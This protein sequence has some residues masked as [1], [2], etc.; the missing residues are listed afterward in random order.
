[1]M[2]VTY[3]DQEIES[4]VRERKLLPVNWTRRARLMPKRGHQERHLDI[5]GDLG[6]QFR[7]ILRQ[8]T[9]NVLDFSAILAVRVPQSNQV[10]RLRR[11]NG[12]SHE[13]TNHIEGGTFYDFHIHHATERYQ[14]RSAREDAYAEPTDRYGTFQEA[15]RC[16]LADANFDVPNEQQRDFFEENGNGN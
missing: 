13:H 9:A 6:N 16:L 14:D 2:A 10:F 4:L 5:T 1:M 15:L 8:S 12:R 7:V 3:T 11:Y